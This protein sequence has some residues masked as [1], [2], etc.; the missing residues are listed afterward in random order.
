M[1]D[2]EA[3]SVV[4]PSSRLRDNL[5]ALESLME[6][7][8]TRRASMRIPKSGWIRYGIGDASGNGYGASVRIG[9]K[10]H[11]MYGNGLL[12]RVN[13]LQIIGSFIT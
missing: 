13:N 12:Q 3:P 2:K 6:G 8:V 9:G 10:L 11:N 5:F 7:N 4:E 1:F